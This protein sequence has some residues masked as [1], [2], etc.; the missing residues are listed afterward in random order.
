MFREMMSMVEEVPRQICEPHQ[1][2]GSFA[3]G[4][5]EPHNIQRE[6]ELETICLDF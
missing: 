6:N 5:A 4:T 1:Q 3:D 2:I